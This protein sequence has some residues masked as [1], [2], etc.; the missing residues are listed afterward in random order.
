MR[1]PRLRT[2]LLAPLALFAMFYVAGAVLVLLDDSAIEPIVHSTGS[3]TVAIFGA[4]STRPRPS[5]SR[6]LSATSRVNESRML[7][8]LNARLLAQ[9]S[10]GRF[11]P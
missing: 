10:P 7:P 9:P 11:S 8:N 4:D 1:F 2:I 5:L 6:V 3:R